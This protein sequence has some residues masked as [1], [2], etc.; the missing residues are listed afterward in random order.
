MKELVVF[1]LAFTSTLCSDVEHQPRVVMDIHSL[2]ILPAPSKTDRKSKQVDA[3]TCG[4]TNVLNYGEYAVLESPNY[5]RRYPNNQD[6]SWEIVIP[7]GAQVFFSCEY[8]WV[9]RGDYFIYGDRHPCWGSGVFLLRIFLGEERRLLHLWRSSSL[10]G[11]R[12]FSP[13]NISG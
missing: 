13:A 9:R 5:P 10:L 8:F 2:G 11:L 3:M 7:A 4:S 1:A 12:C 6:C